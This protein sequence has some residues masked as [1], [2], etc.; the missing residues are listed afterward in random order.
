[1]A[2]NLIQDGSYITVPAPAAVSSGDVVTVGTHLF[3][4][5]I[6]DAASGADVTI[7][8]MGVWSLKKKAA[9][10]MTLGQQAFWDTANAEVLKATAS[11]VKIIGVVVGG[12]LS[13]NAGN[14]FVKLNQVGANT[15][16]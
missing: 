2:K 4:V 8:T 1:M 15:K 11:G 3:G 12:V 14:V 16:A 9:D 5:A 13:A 7:A 6:H 10:A